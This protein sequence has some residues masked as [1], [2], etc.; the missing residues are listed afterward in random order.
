[1]LAETEQQLLAEP[2]KRISHL[3]TYIETINE[4]K[5]KLYKWAANKSDH[6]QLVQIERYHN[7]FHIQLINIHD[8]KHEVKHHIHEAERFPNI[9]HRIPHHFIKEKIDTLIT[10]LEKLEHEFHQFITT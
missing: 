6:D 1:M 3:R 5:N 2:M 8:L 9:G 7:Q 10:D 4:L